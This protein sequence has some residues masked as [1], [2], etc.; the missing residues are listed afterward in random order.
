MV[1]ELRWVGL[2]SLNTGVC[3]LFLLQSVRDIKSLQV[4]YLV[5]GG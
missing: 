3:V 4:N 1:D 5:L 2:L